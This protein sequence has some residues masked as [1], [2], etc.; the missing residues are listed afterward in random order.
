[1]KLKTKIIGLETGVPVILLTEKNANLL[2][3]N[4]GGRATIKKPSSKKE[5]SV[6]VDISNQLVS[7]KQI[8]ISKETKDRLSLERGYVL[9]VDVAEIPDS[10]YFI[11]KKIDK[12]KLTEK[13]IN[14]IIK[15]VVD[16]SLS[17]PE[18]SMF[19]SAMYS[20]GMTYEE[21]IYLIKAILKSGNL[22]KF[23]NKY[24]VDKH[25]IGGIP[26]NRTT[27]IVVSICA[28]AGLIMPKNSSRAITSAAGT[29]DVIEAMA[30]VEFSIKELK[31]IIKKTNAC[32]VWGGSLGIV[33]ADSKIINIEKSLN[34]DP[35]AQLLA[36]IMSKK[37]ASDSNYILIDIPYGKGAK[38]DKK[39]ALHLKRKFE[40]IG[41]YF[42]RIIKVVLT[43]G[44]QPI[45]NGVGPELE[46]RDVIKVLKQEEDSP[47]DLEDKSLFLAGTLLEM[48][49]KVKDGSGM[50]FAKSILV[51]GKAYEKFAQIIK[52]QRGKIRKIKEAKYK[53]E[54][55]A[56]KSGI[57]REI[58]NKKINSLARIA[59]CPSFKA[60]GLYLYKHLGQKIK[61][62]EKL[63]TIYSDSRSRLN[64]AKDFYKKTSP[65]K[66]N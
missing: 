16:N 64:Q 48:T 39:R 65:I 40:K 4:V 6:I 1:M 60:S 15:D 45:G 33:P 25:S 61:K 11:K 58:N 52:A 28:A 59:G 31:Q 35:E 19:I 21:T 3:V 38:V 29:A 55:L 2:G 8:G 66:I 22:L 14:E 63:I 12:K 9:D 7:D 43:K 41:N 62:G 24:V 10:L 5:L 54:I 13:E 23:R 27:P 49:G 37:L 53:K 46:L 57:I 20:R 26:G 56:N 44:D 18:I 30:K 47:K 36:S 17:S 42:D 50:S 34:V 32:M 51:S